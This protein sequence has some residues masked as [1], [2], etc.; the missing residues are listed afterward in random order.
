MPSDWKEGL[1][2]ESERWVRLGLISAQ[3]REAI[4]K[5]YPQDGAAAGRDRTVLIMSILGSLL[6]GA[7]VILYFAANWP[8][9]PATIKVVLI[10]AAMLGSYG[11]GFYFQYRRGDSPR[12]GQA[13]I[14]LGS[15]L[16]G[17][18]IWLVAQIFHIDSDF[19]TGFLAWGAGILPLVWA[20]G[21]R[22]VLYLA[23]VTLVVWTVGAQ[24][25]MAQYNYLFP[26]LMLGAVLPLSRRTETRLAESAILLSV[27]LWYILNA[28]RTDLSE[29]NGAAVLMV[30]RLALLYGVVVMLAGLNRLGDGRTY[31]G[32]GTFLALIGLYLLTFSIPRWM[33]PDSGLLPSLFAGSPYTVAGAVL[34][35]AGV[36]AG[37]VLY[38]RS[39]EGERRWL[40]PAVLLPVAAVLLAEWLPEVGRMVLFNLLLLAGVVGV[41]ALGIQRRMELLVNLGLVTFAIHLLTRYF[42]L[43]FR[44]MD[45]SFFFM[46]GGVLLL[47]GGWYLERNRRRWVGEM[48]GGGDE[49]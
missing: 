40:L 8:R 7:G 43:F 31:L 19:P 4:L 18:S 11:A 12:L 49:G 24:T 6:V 28:G 20:T 48:G 32:S 14:F 45:R 21:S 47:V 17:A 34:L 15:L 13:L 27:F 38:L 23:T 46:M 41:V 29:A 2:P 42:D 22:P 39:G 35:L 9:I 30:G 3:Q 1:R 25:E 10:L 37:V 26:V 36:A 16:Y 44:A 5:L 33:L